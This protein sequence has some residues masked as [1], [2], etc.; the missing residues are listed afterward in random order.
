MEEVVETEEVL[1]MLMTLRVPA[2]VVALVR[3]KLF[4]A[5]LLAEEVAKN[6]ISG[7]KMESKAARARAVVTTLAGV[8]CVSEHVVL[9][10]LV[11]ISQHL[12]SWQTHIQTIKFPLF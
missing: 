1:M 9:A 4:T 11:H 5:K 6:V 8:V 7:V 12:M 10:P 2:V 3:V